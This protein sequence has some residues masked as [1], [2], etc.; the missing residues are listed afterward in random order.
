MAYPVLLDEDIKLC[1]YHLHSEDE[2]P[3]N[4]FLEGDNIF[5]LLYSINNDPPVNSRTLTLLETGQ[6][7]QSVPVVGRSKFNTCLP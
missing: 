4:R 1:P 7:Y 2:W 3:F 6:D 5:L